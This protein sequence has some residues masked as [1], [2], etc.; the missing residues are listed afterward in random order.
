MGVAPVFARPEF[1]VAAVVAPDPAG[2]LVVSWHE[3]VLV[4]HAAIVRG[5]DLVPHNLTVRRNA[6]FIDAHRLDLSAYHQPMQPL[7]CPL[8]LALEVAVALGDARR[9]ELARGD[10][11]EAGLEQLVLA[12][13][14]G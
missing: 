5:L 3:A 13:A 6:V 14:E 1:L 7:P 12:A 11:C 9:L 2:R 10:G 8:N 4:A